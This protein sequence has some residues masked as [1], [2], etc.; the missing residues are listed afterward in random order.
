MAPGLLIISIMRRY[1]TFFSV[2]FVLF[3]LGSLASAAG[4]RPVTAAGIVHEMNIARQNPGLY[5]GYVEELRSRFAGRVLILPGGTR[6]LS[7]EGLRAIDEAARFLRRVNPQP[8]LALSPGMCRA[9]AD[10]CADQ[11]AGRRG[12][13]GSDRSTPGGRI[14]RYGA[15]G[16]AWGENIAYGK[17]SA[18]DIVLALIIDDGQPARKHRKNIFNPKFNYAGAA[19]GPHAIFGSVCSIDFA[20]AYA[21]RQPPNSAALVARNF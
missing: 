20:G 10:H 19:Y 8:P 13:D 16:R 11:A 14:S 17:N 7:H 2:F 6:I 4:D 1:L 18:R 15:W 3:S 5:A 9:A 12:H 21:E